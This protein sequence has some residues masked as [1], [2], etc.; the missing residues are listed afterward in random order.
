MTNA[1]TSGT[2]SCSACTVTN[3][4]AAVLDTVKT[5]TTVNGDP[6]TATTPVGPGD[7]LVYDLTVTNSGGTAG[8]HHAERPGPGPHDLHRQRAG[9]VVRDRGRGRHRVQ[10]VGHRARRTAR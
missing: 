2:G 5:I 4:T 1:V 6:A 3:P 8:R 7:V 10:P 9:L